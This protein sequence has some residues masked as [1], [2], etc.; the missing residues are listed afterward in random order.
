MNGTGESH[1]ERTIG[2]AKPFG[3]QSP[4]LRTGIGMWASRYLS[5][6]VITHFARKV[7]ATGYVDQ[8]VVWDQ[9]MNWFPQGLWEPKFSPLAGVL[10]DVDSLPDPFAAAAFALSGVEKIGFAVCTDSLRRE[11]A[12]LAQTMLTLATATEGRATLFL[13]AGEARHVIPFGRKRSLGIKRLEEALPI[14]RLLLKEDKP[15][16]FDGQIWKM[17]DAF[18]GNGG[19]D[20][21]PEVMAM[22]SGPRLVAAAL[23]YADGFSTGAP[24]VFAD[25]V[26]YGKVIRGHKQ[27]LGD[28]GRGN[29]PF[30][31][32]LHH[33]AFLCDGKDDFERYVDNPLLKWYAATGGRINQADW[34]KEGIE[35]VMP[36]DWHYAF[37]MLPGSMTRDEILA[38][39][40]RVPPEM[41]R[42]T[43][44]YGTPEEVAAEI[45]PF[46]EQGAD[47][48]LIADV[49]GLVFET[50]PEL[51]IERLAEVCRLI[52]AG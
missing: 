41:V 7:E 18:L 31:F 29:E 13:G 21:R 35:P 36:V 4:P 10:P 6:K 32:A 48:H 46:A 26:E 27:T 34:A 37:K 16:D 52:K 3:H 33:I 45:R 40:D 11:P 28:L 43:F 1:K 39:A 5:P 50:N 38:I 49:S 23:R 20:R 24:F 19:K 14:L 15:V 51:K 2:Q 30:S 44:F 42:K 8:L 47:C 12:E 25:P 9:L 22:G 17:R